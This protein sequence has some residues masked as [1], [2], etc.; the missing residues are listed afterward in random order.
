MSPNQ[1][2]IPNG[3]NKYDY[4]HQ[5]GSYSTVDL[6]QK[7]CSYA[8]YLDKRICKHLV[9]AC[10]KTTTNLPGLVFLP[11]VLVTRWKR[12]KPI[13]M[14]PLK[15]STMT[16]DQLPMTNDQLPMANDQLLNSNEITQSSDIVTSKSR[17][18][19]PRKCGKALDK[20]E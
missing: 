1:L 20:D 19:R 16:N 7:I 2:L 3:D 18:G 14:S 13:Y 4:Y 5:D 9:A 11:K 10:I 17:V 15:R 12:K 8:W 6:D